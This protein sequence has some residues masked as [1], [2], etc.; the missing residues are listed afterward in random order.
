MSKCRLANGES[1]EQQADNPQP[2]RDPRLSRSSYPR[3]LPAFFCG[4][5]APAGGKGPSPARLS[6]AAQPS[7]G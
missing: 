1:R 2:T 4:V 3:T 7:G 5:A 6:L